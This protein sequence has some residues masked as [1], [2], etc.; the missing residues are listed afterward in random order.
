MDEDFLIAGE[1]N[2]SR[3]GGFGGRGT[4]LLEI[5]LSERESDC[6]CGFV[7]SLGF[8]IENSG[9][10]TGWVSLLSDPMKLSAEPAVAVI[11]AASIVGAGAIRLRELRFISK[12]EFGQLEK[13]PSN[14]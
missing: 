5:E 8:G 9:S 12:R 2:R 7:D 1:L 4:G 13:E 14:D 3:E 10:G 11:A 6:N